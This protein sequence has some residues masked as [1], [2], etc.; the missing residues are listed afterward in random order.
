MENITESNIEW[1]DKNYQAVVRKFANGQVEVTTSVVRA[2]QQWQRAEQWA[3]QG[4]ELPDDMTP[5]QLARID[6]EKASFR[7]R[8]ASRKVKARED[9]DQCEIERLEA[10]LKADNIARAVRRA[11]QQVRWHCRMLAVDHLLTLTYRENMEDVERLKADWKEFVRRVRLVKPQW[12]F[13]AVR[14]R[15]ERGALHLHVAVHGR[16]DIGL[17]RRCWYQALGGTGKEQGEATPGQV[18]VSGPSKRYGSRTAE[19]KINK[20][21]G[22]MCKYLDKAFEEL[23]S[24]GSKRY[25]NSKGIPEPEVEKI[26][27]SSS[28]FVDAVVD[29]HKI[30]KSL[31]PW[32]VSLWA[33]EGYDCIWLAG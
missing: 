29:S 18:D 5:A 23:D 2:M 22:Y 8:A 11:R 4:A 28:S 16:Q 31:R 10:Q 19:W 12:E 9:M 6:A 1:Q 15:Q 21:T 13:V 30:F 7:A 27:L 3:A 14:E 33:S 17:I 24:K 20:L 32:A 26:W 25:W